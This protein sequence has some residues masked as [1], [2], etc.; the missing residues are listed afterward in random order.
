MSIQQS[1]NFESFVP[2]EKFKNLNKSNKKSFYKSL[3]K[4]KHNFK[5]KKNIFYSFSK[6]FKL[7]FSLS[8]LKKYK[9]FK[10]IITIGMGGSILGSQAINF[11]LKKKINKELI[12]INNLDPDQ[13]N[14]LKRI[15]NLNNSLFIFISKSGNTIEVLQ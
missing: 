2:N 4:V 6:N 5:E 1:I 9:R 8:E 7:N 13:L 12:F 3:K 14:K 11:F 15:K 10:R